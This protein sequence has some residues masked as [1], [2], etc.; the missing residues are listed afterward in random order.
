MWLIRVLVENKNLRIP[1]IL[2]V[3]AWNIRGRLGSKKPESTKIFEDRKINITV[4]P[5]A[6][7]NCRGTKIRSRMSITSIFNGVGQN[8]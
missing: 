7:K 5:V 8:Q 3:S 2:V 1:D 4:I 6:K